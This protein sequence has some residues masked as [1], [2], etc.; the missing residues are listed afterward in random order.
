MASLATGETNCPPT[1]H[2]ATTVY[3]EYGRTTTSTEMW[4]SAPHMSFPTA[5]LTESAFVYLMH[6]QGPLSQKGSCLSPLQMGGEKVEV[7]ILRAQFQPEETEQRE[8]G[9]ARP[10]PAHMAKA[11][12]VPGL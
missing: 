9:A 1:P 7:R 5:F 2:L 6:F 11:V 3:K 8:G 4:D 10:H 12:P